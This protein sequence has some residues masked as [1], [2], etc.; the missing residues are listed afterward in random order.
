ML[1]MD[2]KQK[3]HTEREVT[4]EKSIRRDHFPRKLIPPFGSIK[5]LIITP[6]HLISICHGEDQLSLK[7]KHLPNNSA[8]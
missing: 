7:A 1:L 8:M 5:K 3:I 6:M 2:K 4:E